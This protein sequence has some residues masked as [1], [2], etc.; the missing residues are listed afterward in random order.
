MQ[1]YKLLKPNGNRFEL[2]ADC[3]RGKGEPSTYPLPTDGADFVAQLNEAT[4]NNPPPKRDQPLLEQLAPLG[5]GPGLSPEDAGLDPDVLAALYEGV[6]DEQATLATASK[7]NFVQQSIDAKGWVFAD[8]DIG[9]FGTDYLLRA[10]IAVVGIGA[11]TPEEA[12]YPG[13]LADSDGALLNGANDYE[14]VFPADEAPP[15][16]YFWSLTMYDL[17]GF[18]VDNPI[19]RYSLGPSHPP[20]VVCDDGSIA[21]VISQRASR[22]RQLAAGAERR[23]PPQ[24][25]PLRAAEAGAERQ[26][27]ATGARLSFRRATARPDRGSGRRSTGAFELPL[28]QLDPADLAGQGLR[29]L[30][31]ELDPARVGVGAKAAADVAPGSRSASSSEGSWPSARTMNALTT[32]PRRSSGEA[33][34]AA[35]RTAGCSRQADSTS[36]G[37]I[38]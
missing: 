24:H 22:R 6:E 19:D 13:A 35:S 36:N 11:N 33:T 8:S 18:L 26:L 7:L 32:L 30:V 31:D 1:R 25:A 21:V 28:A 16:R 23:V 4:V 14:M 38:R 20:L 17:D 34:A 15:A 12:V 27:D 9:D 5:V 10:R 3:H 29:Q 2:P 37:P